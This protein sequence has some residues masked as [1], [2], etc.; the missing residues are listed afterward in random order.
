[1]RGRR[2][3]RPTLTIASGGGGERRGLADLDHKPWAAEDGDAWI[4]AFP[5]DID[6]D[7]TT[8]MELSV[9]P[10]I[11]VTL[12]GGGDEPAGPGDVR[13]AGTSAR[14][15]LA[16]STPELRH[17]SRAADLERIG[18]RLAAA[19][20]EAERERER[21][22]SLGD[23][24][25]Q[26]RSENRKLRT[27]VGQLK[28]ELELAQAAQ[29]EASATAAEL[30]RMRRDLRDAQ[31]RNE[32]LTRRHQETVDAAAAARSELH[33]H[34]GALESAREA[35]ARE[36]A[37]SGRLRNRL[38]S[39]QEARSRPEPL[40]A[41]RSR[42]DD[43]APLPAS[44]RTTE[45]NPEASGRSAPRPRGQAASRLA[46]PQARPSG[47]RRPDASRDAEAPPERQASSRAPSE[48]RPGGEPRSAVDPP[49]HRPQL[50]VSRPAPSTPGS[51]RPLNPSLRHRT[52]WLGRLLALLLLLGVIAVVVLIIHGTV[53]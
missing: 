39:V 6:L 40:S 44:D 50:I 51:Q 42:G 43:T 38:S 3:V 4:A 26:E 37:E 8:E 5:I 2:F 1:V 46:A 33:E 53:S 18:A 25:E 36:R 12:I 32:S 14:S 52:W 15:P 10:D 34:A 28:A 9:A 30:E 41:G 7:E 13:M 16:K 23:A 27:E 20:R 29:G 48:R 19:Q 35:L 49:S 22:A 31:Q 24:L 47:E 11:A 17:R 45:R 21:R